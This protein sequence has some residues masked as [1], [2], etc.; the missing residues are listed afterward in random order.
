MS[1]EAR[2]EAPLPAAIGLR[3]KSGRAVAVVLRGPAA[4][5]AVVWRGELVLCTPDRRQP[6]HPFI[7]LPWPEAA[8]AVLPVAREIEATAASALRDLLM[9][10]RAD[11][12][13]IRCAGIVGAGQRDP[14][15]VGNPHIR[16][17]AAEGVLFREVL[18]AAAR[19]NGLPSVLFPERELYEI[20]GRELGLDGQQ[21][22]SRLADLGRAVGSPWRGDEK[23]A[24]LAAWCSVAGMGWRAGT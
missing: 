1:P 6:Y 15:R 4:S 24:A 7:D 21:I 17:H 14:A 9:R 13:I 10:L 12:A 18:E 11:D 19:A 5:P 8:A 23:A 2:E 20:A 3:A 22:K 16:A